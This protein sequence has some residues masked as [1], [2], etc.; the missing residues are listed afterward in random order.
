MNY[1]VRILEGEPDVNRSASPDEEGG[2]RKPGRSF[3]AADPATLLLGDFWMA[4]WMDWLCRS[5][6]SAGNGGGGGQQGGGGGGPG[7]GGGSGNGDDSM[8]GQF[9]ACA[10]LQQRRGQDNQRRMSGSEYVSGKSL[11]LCP[12]PFIILLYP[13]FALIYLSALQ[14]SIM[15]PFTNS[16]TN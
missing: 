3:S 13:Q 7:S 5:A 2:I 11:P 14:I 4:P 6:A 16:L 10:P 9:T 8:W 15:L 12:T 1:L